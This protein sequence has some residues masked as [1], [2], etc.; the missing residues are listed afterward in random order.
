MELRQFVNQAVQKTTS[1]FSTAPRDKRQRSERK[2]LLEVM[3]GL[4]IAAQGLNP[5]KWGRLISTQGTPEGYLYRCHCGTAYPFPGQTIYAQM[6][7]HNRPHCGNSGCAKVYGPFD[8]LGDT[9]QRVPAVDTVEFKELLAKFEGDITAD[10]YA[11]G[12]DGQYRLL[13]EKRE[14]LLM[15]LPQIPTESAADDRGNP[16]ILPTDGPDFKVEWAGSAQHGTDADPFAG[17]PSFEGVATRASEKSFEYRKRRHV[18]AYG[19]P[20]E[21]RALAAHEQMEEDTGKIHYRY[22]TLP[23]EEKR[24]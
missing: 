2:Y 13:D 9:R 21:K 22:V 12:S 4:R 7:A 10:D 14:R 23:A 18:R 6:E 8:F 19:T 1:I 17:G 16:L 20:E 24:G 3:H 15:H 5:G 11:K